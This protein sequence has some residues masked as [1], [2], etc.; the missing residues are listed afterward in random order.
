MNSIANIFKL[1]LAMLV[2]SA[3]SVTFCI[4][5]DEVKTEKESDAPVNKITADVAAEDQ[6]VQ[7][8]TDVTAEDQPAKDKA[9]NN[10]L[11]TVDGQP[12][13]KEDLQTTLDELSKRWKDA[14]RSD[15]EVSQL[16][17]LYRPQIIE[18][19]VASKLIE[20][21][22]EA[23]AIVVSDKELEEAYNSFLKTLPP[24][25]T[26]EK[27]EKTHGVTEEKIK[28]ELT[29]Q[30]K[31][32]KL[33]KPEEPSEDDIREYYEAN[34][35]T[36]VRARHIL[37]KV[38]KSDSDETKAEQLKKIKEIKQQL[39]DGADF[40]KLAMEHSDCPSKQE[41]GDLGF[42]A[43]GR[44]VKPFSD[45]A[46]ALE[47][48]KVSEPVETD[49]GF[50]LIETLE[51]RTPPPLDEVR[52]NVKHMLTERQI[53]HASMAM[54]EELKAKAKIEYSEKESTD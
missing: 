17:M 33:V 2:I 11:V 10:I 26:I 50:H 41:G 19:L 40:A 14:G 25:M 22:C 30:V 6:P 39:D 16:V 8:K 23:Q 47:V 4:G 18:M 53:Q 27:L 49:F 29:E 38:E 7:E 13:T 24:G 45:A 3:V 48:N 5:D 42:F 51:K 37:L 1:G 35:Q 44:M 54:V 15:A 46:F 36:E 34:A 52:E 43:A 21:A 20:N 9:D 31:L 28:K 12:I 32:K